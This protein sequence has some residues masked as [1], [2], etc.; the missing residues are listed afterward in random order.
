MRLITSCAFAT[1]LIAGPF[2]AAPKPAAAETIYPWCAIYSERTVGATNCGF[3]TL[4][5]CRAT[6]S[7]IGG[8]CVENPEYRPAERRTA[9]KRSPRH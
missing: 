8:M 2:L 7:G 5:Q 9:P 6:I 4:A 3:S 1:L